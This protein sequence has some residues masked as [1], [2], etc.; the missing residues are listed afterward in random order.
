MYKGV[1]VGTYRADLIIETKVLVEV[2]ATKLLSESDEK[3]VLNYLKATG[4][5]LGLLLNFGP[6]PS[7]R[8]L[9]FSP[10]S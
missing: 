10:R 9:I 5:E 8:R 4:L 6:K 1:E 3:Q 2:K 7:F